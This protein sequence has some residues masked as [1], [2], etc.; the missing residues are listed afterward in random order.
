VGGYLPK[1]REDRDDNPVDHLLEF[2]EVMH[3]LGI[4]HEDVLVKMSMY[5]LEGEAGE[6]FRSLSTSSISSLKYFHVAFHNH[7]KKYF[8]AN[9][10]F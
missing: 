1:F 7:C 2:H 10:L 6:W 8:S 4:H 3:Q 9:L 5:S